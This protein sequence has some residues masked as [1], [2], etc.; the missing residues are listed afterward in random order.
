MKIEKFEQSGFIIES[1][2][3]F[4][5]GLDIGSYT[6]VEKL[7]GIK[8]DAMI[9]SHLH[10]DHLSPD[11]IKKLSPEKLYISYECQEALGEDAISSEI[12]TIKTDSQVQI[13]DIK[14]EIFSVDHGPNVPQPK[15]NF[16][17]L[18]T[19]DDQKIYFPGDIFYPSGMDVTKLEVDYAML[20]IGTFYTFGPE[21]AFA[22][23]KTFK[24]IGKLVSMHDRNNP[25]LKE[26][27]LE[28]AK[29]SFDVE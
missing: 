5:L 13:G 26:R 16:G 29:D 14:V 11:Q 12:V 9:V 10:R 28:L 4:R 1:E 6:P 20:P 2:K 21:E 3:G 18:F 27:F 17:F 19:V 23:A 25:E 7:D 15:E 24:K 8:V 22:F